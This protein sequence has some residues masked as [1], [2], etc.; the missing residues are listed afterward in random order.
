MVRRILSVAV[1][2]LL[3]LL[4]QLPFLDAFDF[5]HI[6][7]DYMVLQR[8]PQSSRIWGTTTTPSDTLTLTL[9]GSLLRLRALSSAD[10]AFEFLLPPQ[11]ASTNH[12]ITISAKEG[13]R[14]FHD[15]AFGDVY[16]CSGQSNMS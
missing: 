2:S 15:V 8:A 12:T 10:G 14:T 16:I 7:D 6:I 3:V 1:L 4:A 5:P 13:E 11:P 9:D